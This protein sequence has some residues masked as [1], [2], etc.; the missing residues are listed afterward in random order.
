MP[1]PALARMPNSSNLEVAPWLE[2]VLPPVVEEH[3]EDVDL[4]PEPLLPE[5][6]S[7]IELPREMATKLDQSQ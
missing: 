2:V 3:L 6:Q 4:N 7:V 1:R 5:S